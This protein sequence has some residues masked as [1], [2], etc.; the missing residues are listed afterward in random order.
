MLK[1][2]NENRENVAK[3]NKLHKLEEEE[4]NMAV[5]IMDEAKKK[6]SKTRKHKEIQVI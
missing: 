6:M 5:T 3:K 4:E 1:N 2:L